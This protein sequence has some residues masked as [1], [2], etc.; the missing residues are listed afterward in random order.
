MNTESISLIIALLAVIFG[1]LVQIKIARMQLNASLSLNRRKD[2]ID[3]LRDNVS[4]FVQLCTFIYSDQKKIQPM[5]EQKLSELIDKLYYLGPKISLLIDP[6]NRLHENLLNSLESLK[7]VSVS[8]ESAG[9]DKKHAEL[10]L[11]VISQAQAII[12]EEINLI[13]KA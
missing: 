12:S 3:L 9:M 10:F 6:K 4:E 11:T 1:P 2:R 13:E 5:E 8:D 7:V